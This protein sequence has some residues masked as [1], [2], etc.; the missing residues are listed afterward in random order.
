MKCWIKC[1]KN[2][3]QAPANICRRAKSINWM[4]WQPFTSSWSRNS[5]PPPHKRRNRRIL[6]S[7][8]NDR[9]QSKPMTE[10]KLN[11]I[12]EALAHQELQIETLSKMAAQQF[13]VID[14]LK[15]K[16]DALQKKIETLSE[17][18]LSENDGLSSI[19]QMRNEKPPHY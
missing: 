15:R 19:E 7:R 8:N 14:V 4:N 18:G 10:E 6:P 12:E 1:A 3:P 16:V 13:D 11:A 17:D 5:H 9:Q 2:S